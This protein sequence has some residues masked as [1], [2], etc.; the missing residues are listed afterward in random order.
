MADILRDWYYLGND[1]RGMTILRGPFT[2]GEMHDLLRTGTIDGATRVRFMNK[3]VWKPLRDLPT[4]S[5][6]FSEGE[7]TPTPRFWTRNKIAAAG[8]AVAVLCGVIS[9]QCAHTAPG[10]EATGSFARF[11]LSREALTKDAIVGLTNR[12]RVQN[13]LPPLKENLLLVA[14]AEARARD[15]FEKQ[16]FGHVS[17]TG[18]QASDLAQSLGYPYRRIAENIASGNFLTNQH[19]INGWMQSPG[20]RKNLLSP[21]VEEIGA[22]VVKGKLEG[23]ETSIAVQI[24]GLQSPQVGQDNCV[25]PSRELLRDIDTKNAEIA[26]LGERLARLKAE[27]EAEKASIEADR[28]S[29]LADPQERYNFNV[30]VKA[31]NE[32]GVWHNSM[33]A[34]LNGKMVAVQSMTHE[35]TRLQQNYKDCTGAK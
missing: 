15:M 34:E 4:F 13:S 20:H 18:Q 16:Y 6:L 25:P 30:R 22:A 29:A 31:H 35:Y 14:I 2:T 9:Y 17:P 1:W 26:S 12:T 8:V 5:K 11:S 24:F 7:P 10:A 28:S 33:V 3:G 21:D 27:L 32:K 23:Q 19:I